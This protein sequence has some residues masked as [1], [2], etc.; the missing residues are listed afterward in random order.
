MSD[1]DPMCQCH[2]PEQWCECA[3][4]ALDDE[5]AKADAT[6]AWE[7]EIVYDGDPKM[8]GGHERRVAGRLR[9][10]EEALRGLKIVR[11]GARHSGGKPN[12]RI[13]RRL[14]GEWEVVDHE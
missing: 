1:P 3:P 4:I 8:D 11:M 9:T 14:V 10:F 5:R 13:E 12:L 2:V 7:Y 6:Q